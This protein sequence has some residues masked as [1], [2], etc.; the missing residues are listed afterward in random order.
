[1]GVY[2][3][4]ASE[5]TE[6]FNYTVYYNNQLVYAQNNNTEVISTNR[7]VVPTIDLGMRWWF[8][9]WNF[10]L[11][12]HPSY[13]IMPFGDNKTTRTDLNT[14][15]VDTMTSYSSF[16]MTGGLMYVWDYE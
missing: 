14:K 7:R 16:S 8:K 1:M 13:S 9:V 3:K 10:R 15:K 11:Y 4:K 12:V 5:Q 2:S 6:E